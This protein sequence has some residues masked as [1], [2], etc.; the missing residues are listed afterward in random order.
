LWTSKEERSVTSDVP[1]PA[2]YDGDFFVLSDL[3][4]TLSRV[5]PKSGKVKWSIKTPGGSKYEASPL[6]AD[7]K[8][9]LVNFDGEVVIVDAKQGETI[10]VISMVGERSKDV[11]RSSIIAADGQLFVR[12][13]RK[14]Y[15]VGQ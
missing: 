9:Y 13:N 14:L 10:N 12:T 1:T 8:I 7:G 2:F 4:K 3:T 5:E 6:A 15:C 11:V